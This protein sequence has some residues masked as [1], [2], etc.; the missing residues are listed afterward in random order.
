VRKRILI[1]LNIDLVVQHLLR[2]VTQQNTIKLTPV[3]DEENPIGSTAQIRT[4]YSTRPNTQTLKSHISHVIGDSAWEQY[5]ANIFES[6]EGVVC[7]E[8]PIRAC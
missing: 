7:T 6:H 2:Y 5:A 3:Y 1:A 4:W 8:N